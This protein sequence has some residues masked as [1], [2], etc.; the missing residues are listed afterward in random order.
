VRDAEQL[1]VGELDPGPRIA[2]VE[3]H[4]DP[5]A[6]SSAYRRSASSRTRSD[7]GMFSGTSTRERRDRR[8]PDDAAASWF[9][10]IAAATMRVTPMP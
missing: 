7:F 10:S 1:G 6:V 9:C 8:R 4:L 3:Q 5:A 2:V